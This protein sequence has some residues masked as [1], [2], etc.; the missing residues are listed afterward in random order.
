MYSSPVALGLKFL[1]GTILTL[2]RIAVLF[3]CVRKHAEQLPLAG[4]HVKDT[5]MLIA[6]A[7]RDININH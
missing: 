2:T 5:G 1:Q 3:F 4:R 7:W 6:R